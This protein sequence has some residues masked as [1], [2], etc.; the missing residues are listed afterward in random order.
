VL[1]QGAKTEIDSQAQKQFGQG[2]G[3]VLHLGKIVKKNKHFLYFHNYF[4]SFNLFERL[5]QIGICAA[6]TIRVNWFAKPSILSDTITI[7]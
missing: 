2:P 4:S 6:G 1:Y 7:S 3:V 5:Q